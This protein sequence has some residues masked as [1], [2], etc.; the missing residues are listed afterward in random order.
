MNN[1][2]NLNSPVI[3]Y[4]K[5]MN[6]ELFKNFEEG[7]L[8]LINSQNYNPIYPKLFLMN[9]TNYNKINLNNDWYIDNI[10]EKINENKYK[11]VLKH[12]NKNIQPKIEIIY[13]KFVPLYDPEKFICDKNKNKTTE[14]KNIMSN[15]SLPYYDLEKNK[16][17]EH[18][19]QIF[20]NYEETPE[21][22]MW[23]PNNKAYIDSFFMY[24]SNTLYKRGFINGIE[25][26][27]SFLGYKKNFQYNIAEDFEML[28]QNVNF[29]KNMNSVFYIKNIDYLLYKLNNKKELKISTKS[30]C[31]DASYIDEFLN[32]ED[33]DDELQNDNV[34]TEEDI[35][36]VQELSLDDFNFENIDDQ[37]FENKNDST[38]LSNENISSLTEYNTSLLSDEYN[39]M[40]SKSSSSKSSYTSTNLSDE[41]ND[42]SSLNDEDWKTMSNSSTSSTISSSVDSELEQILITIPYYP[43]KAIFIESYKCTLDKLICSGELNTDD[44]WLSM[45]MQIIMTLLV[46]Q[47]I[48]K[49]THNDLHVDNIMYLET[50]EQYIFYKYNKIIYKV[51]TY[52]KIFKIIDFGRAIYD[53]NNNV[54]C[55]DDFHPK[56]N[57]S[58]QYNTFP[59]FNNKKEEIKRNFSFDLTRLACSIFDYLLTDDDDTICNADTIL[60]C[61]DPIKRI[62]GEW[63]LDDKGK[64]MLYKSSGEE[65]YL[66][67]KLYKMISRIVHNH[68]PENQLKRK[69]FKNFIFSN[70]KPKRDKK[71]LIDIDQLIV[72]FSFESSSYK[73]IENIDK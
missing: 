37:T 18:N 31:F 40:Q 56:G 71:N 45:L 22:K 54:Y 26:Y 2:L 10:I 27:G 7:P 17:F 48:F 35:N 20:N 8:E 64:N 58:T 9:E 21:I 33:D 29:G 66:D 1:S 62:I 11:C 73:K 60:K 53:F 50:N 70:Y 32:I 5:R 63:C 23:S 34:E 16:R 28:N 24:L 42:L 46:Y 3:N 57:A 6:I 12:I 36:N 19:N 52:G 30:T 15:F 55:S 72:D 14:L 61:T 25:Y 51:P 65:R 47:K 59:F 41:E 13:V 49:F 39:E 4:K 44:K 43:V 69:E 67:F 38:Y 68:T